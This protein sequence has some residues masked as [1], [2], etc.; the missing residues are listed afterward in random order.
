MWEAVLEALIDSLKMAPILL[1]VYLL[2]EFLE[3]K[4]KVNFENVLVKSKSTGPLWGA[5]LGSLPQCAFSVVMSDLF[6]KRMITIGTLFAV[7]LATSDEAIPIL[8]SQP[9][10]YKTL[11]IL[12]LIKFVLAVI[13]GFSIDLI[14]GKQ[15]VKVKELEDH[16]HDEICTDKHCCADN[17]LVS[18]LKHTAEIFAYVLIAN[19]LLNVVVFYVGEE[20]LASLFATGTIFQPFIASLIGLIPNCVASVLLIELYLSGAITFASVVAGLCTGAGVGM[21]VLFKKNKNLKQNLLI[22]LFLFLIGALVG[23][24]LGLILPPTI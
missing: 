1:L 18:A 3:H 5:A 7:F 15:S 20:T 16:N 13:I 12:L 6:A 10:Q 11:G 8:I 22:I 24:V 4:K 14:V 2:M 17:I 19:I 23:M 21:I 9:E